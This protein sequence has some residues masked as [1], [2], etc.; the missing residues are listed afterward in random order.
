MQRD[1]KTSG[2]IIVYSIEIPVI[3]RT[4]SDNYLSKV[5]WW[6][7]F[8]LSINLENSELI[9]IINKRKSESSIKIINSIGN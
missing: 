1:Q 4:V 7:I 5:Q 9:E 3:I 6:I 2:I 8:K